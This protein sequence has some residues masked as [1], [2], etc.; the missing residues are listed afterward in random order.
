M[1]SKLPDDLAWNPC[2]LP[3]DVWPILLF[4]NGRAGF[5]HPITVIGLVL[6]PVIAESRVYHRV[7]VLDEDNFKTMKKL[8]TERG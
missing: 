8:G 5:R 4:V 7:G 3:S 2:C 1:H 6:K